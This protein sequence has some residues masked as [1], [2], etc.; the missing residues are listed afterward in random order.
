MNTDIL[1]FLVLSEDVLVDLD[2]VDEHWAEGDGRVA[3]T[4]GLVLGLANR[5]LARAVLVD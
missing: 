5:G 4:P 2:L 3:V 1:T